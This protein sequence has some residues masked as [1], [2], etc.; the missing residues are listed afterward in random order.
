MKHFLV[1][2]ALLA[3]APAQA[4]SGFCAARISEQTVVITVPK[5]AESIAALEAEFEPVLKTNGWDRFK[6]AEGELTKGVLK[7]CL[8]FQT[9]EMAVSAMRNKMDEI[10]VKLGSNFL[11]TGW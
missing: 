2:A 10:H 3:A 7:G 8:L 6:T 9:P 11:I 5:E 4:A 1:I